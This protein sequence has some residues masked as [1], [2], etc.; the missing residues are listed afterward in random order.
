MRGER[1]IVR[2]FGNQPLAR[3]V[4]EISENT[5]FITNDEQFKRLM[6]GAE[7]ALMP[8]GFP[9]EDVFEYDS[10]WIASLKKEGESRPNWN[11]LRPWKAR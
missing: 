11:K 1:V 6:E 5:V 8:I 7:D 10:T 2:A 4:W 3:I 9:S